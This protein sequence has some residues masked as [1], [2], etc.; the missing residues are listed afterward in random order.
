MVQITISKNEYAK[1]RRK[2]DAYERLAS[3]IFD[4]VVKDPI[5]EVVDDFRMTGL[6]TQAFL[7][8]LESGLRK[9][10]YGKLW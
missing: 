10:S 8:D 6:Y 5:H 1:L 3:R 4:V 2:A 7:E 9:S